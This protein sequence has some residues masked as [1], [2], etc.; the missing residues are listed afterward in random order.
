MD[1]KDLEAKAKEGDIEAMLKM[2][3]CYSQGAGVKKDAAKAVEW[4]DRAEYRGNMDATYCLA[5][6]YELGAGVKQS[7]SEAEMR[8]EKVAN[9]NSSEAIQAAKHLAESYYSGTG[10]LRRDWASAVS[11]YLKAANA[12]DKDA[13]CR[14]AELYEKG[15]GVKYDIKKVLA[16]YEKAGDTA[17]V[18]R[19]KGLKKNK[20][21]VVVK[22]K[23]FKY[24]TIKAKRKNYHSKY[25]NKRYDDVENQLDWQMLNGWEIV[26]KAED[27]KKKKCEII[28]K[29]KK[30]LLTEKYICVGKTIIE[31]VDGFEYEERYFSREKMTNEYEGYQTD[32]ESNR[33]EFVLW[34]LFC[35]GWDI[36][37]EAENG[38]KTAFR[39][40]LKRNK[41]FFDYREYLR[42]ESDFKSA[43][44]KMRDKL[45]SSQEASY[46]SAAYLRFRAEAE[47]YIVKRYYH[48]YEGLRLR[49]KEGH[50][51]TYKGTGF[52]FVG[53]NSTFYFSDVEYP[54]YEKYKE[55]YQEVQILLLSQK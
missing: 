54:F 55:I 7:D 45:E 47:D 4:W 30:D 25:R 18:E 26:S 50:P 9:S 32:N 8:Y 16:W 35:Y 23:E 52:C 33:M 20:K 22:E 15:H 19:I 2:G 12:G 13:Q 39:V 43:T 44:W 49:L 46:G 11:W 29:I 10:F 48:L 14:L 5:E 6:A 34:K 17:N 37:A 21:I 41:N 27:K 42:I 53:I 51:V 40:V 38:R 36:A 31:K 28:L 1:V 24:Q 3:L